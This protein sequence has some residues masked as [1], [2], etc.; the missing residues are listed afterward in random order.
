MPVFEGYKIAAE[1]RTVES[2]ETRTPLAMPFIFIC[3]CLI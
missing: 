2:C 3:V 1:I